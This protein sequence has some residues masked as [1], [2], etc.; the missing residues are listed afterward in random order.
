[1]KC[2]SL[3]EVILVTIATVLFLYQLYFY[4]RYMAGVWRVA[5]KQK[6]LS[7]AEPMELPGVSVV[8]CARNEADN[9]RDYLSVILE[10]DYPLF[11]VIVINDGSSDETDIVLERFVQLYPHLHLSFVPRGARIVSS[12]KLALTLGVKAAK[13]DYLLFTDADCCPENRKWIRSMMM[14]FT[15]KTDFVL[16]C[17]AYFKKRSL[18]NHLIRYDELFN[19]LQY[20]GMAAAGKPYMGVGRN[21]A[22]SKA[23]FEQKR[24]FSGSLQLRWGYD[25]LFV[26]Q[27]ATGKNTRIAVNNDSL[28]WSEPETSWQGWIRQKERH[29]YSVPYYKLIGRLRLYVEQISRLLFYTAVV[30]LCCTGS[31]WLQ[32]VAGALLCIRLVGQ[33]VLVSLSSRVFGQSGFGIRI[34]LYDMILPFVN[35]YALLMRGRWHYRYG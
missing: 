24:G 28:T 34:L 12:K 14:Q 15:P 23:V 29:L 10:Q 26:N 21:M 13:Y 18:L 27:A 5:R 1:M 8:I 30:L 4:L 16:G 35:G 3:Y 11:E 33:I 7:I 9:L 31:V 32:G 20:L 2:F 22:Y 6:H 17:A 25:D 19:A